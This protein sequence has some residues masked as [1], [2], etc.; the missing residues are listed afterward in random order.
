VM[1]IEQNAAMALSVASHAFVLTVG[2]VTLSGSAEE[3]AADDQV[4]DLYLGRETEAAVD[5]E[6]ATAGSVPLRLRKWSP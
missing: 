1:L 4:R 3:L 6:L 2:V 5:H